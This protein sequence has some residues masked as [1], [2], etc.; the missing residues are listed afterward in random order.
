MVKLPQHKPITYT[1][2]MIECES[3]ILA[4]QRLQDAARFDYHLY[5]QGEFGLEKL[6]AIAKKFAREYDTELT[7]SQR[8]RRKLSSEAVTQFLVWKPESGDAATFWLLTTGGKGRVMDRESFVDLRDKEHRISLTGYELVHDG[9]SWSW[10]MEKT[11]YT[12]HQKRLRN[13]ILAKNNLALEMAIASL[14]GS[15]GFRLVRRQVGMLSKWL[16]AEWL[17]LRKDNEPMPP[18][19]TFLAYVR[20]LPNPVPKKKVKKVVESAKD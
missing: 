10:R 6:P 18:L 9:V 15:P 13:A 2:P 4:M 17:R 11:T 20:R 19:P 14:F 8:S 12:N 16:R 5:F 7:K 1:L 3:K